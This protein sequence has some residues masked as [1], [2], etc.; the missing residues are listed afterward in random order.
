LSG[1]EAVQTSYALTNPVNDHPSLI[2]SGPYVANPMA[3]IRWRESGGLLRKP[4]VLGHLPG[5]D[6]E[7]KEAPCVWQEKLPS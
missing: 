3:R 2:R 7:M 4:T 1:R 5:A 6:T